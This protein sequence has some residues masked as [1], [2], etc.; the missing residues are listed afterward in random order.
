[1]GNGDRGKR[2]S[3]RLKLKR[4]GSEEDEMRRGEKKEKRRFSRQGSSN[5]VVMGK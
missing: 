3:N 4:K 2:V 1:M 5:G